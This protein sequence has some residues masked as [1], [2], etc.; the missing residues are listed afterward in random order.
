MSTRFDVVFHRPTF[1]VGHQDRISPPAG[2]WRIAL[3]GSESPLSAWSIRSVQFRRLTHVKLSVHARM[4][5]ETEI[6]APVRTMIFR[7]FRRSLTTSSIVLYCGSFSRTERLFF[8]ERRQF[9]KMFKLE[10]TYSRCMVL[11]RSFT[12]YSSGIS[13][14]TVTP[15]SFKRL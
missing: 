1:A 4:P 10:Y 5:Q 6:P 14:G 12:A 13:E 8:D 15:N 3:E 2:G 7:D 9:W 11:R